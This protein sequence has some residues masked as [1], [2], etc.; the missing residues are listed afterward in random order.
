LMT[1]FLMR[2]TEDIRGDTLAARLFVT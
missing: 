2:A 1:D